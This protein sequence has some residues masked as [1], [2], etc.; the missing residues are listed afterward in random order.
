[1]VAILQRPRRQSVIPTRR[2]N[3]LA[4]WGKL[5]FVRRLRHRPRW[6]IRTKRLGL[7]LDGAGSGCHDRSGECVGL[8][9]N[10]RRSRFRQ[11]VGANSSARP[12]RPRSESTWL[13]NNGRCCNP[14]SN[15][16]HCSVEHA[17][18]DL[19]ITGDRS[20]L[21]SI[22]A[23]RRLFRA[24]LR[25]ARDTGIATSDQEARPNL[26][27]VV[28]ALRDTA[29]RPIAALPSAAP[30]RTS[31][32]H[33]TP[34]SSAP[35]QQKPNNCC[36]ARTSPNGATPPRDLRGSCGDCTCERC[37]VMST[38]VQVSYAHQ[39]RPRNSGADLRKQGEPRPRGRPRPSQDS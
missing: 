15:S 11:H 5:H 14:M 30:P 3:Q 19:R 34:R 23:H 25:R 39:S 21:L 18:A 1:M 17:H 9:P 32:P 10:R 27:C 37:A 35:Y 16:S 12:R 33:A 22:S 6:P 4:I 26:S 24:E 36:G 38:D 2:I 31:T 28:I 29:R 20:H 8:A 7:I 13:L